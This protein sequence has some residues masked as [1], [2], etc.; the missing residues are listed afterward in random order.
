MKVRVNKQITSLALRG[1]ICATNYSQY[2]QVN[3]CTCYYLLYTPIG[4]PGNPESTLVVGVMSC[5][6]FGWG[7]E[8]ASDTLAPGATLNPM[9]HI[10]SEG[11]RLVFRL[12]HQVPDMTELYPG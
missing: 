4:K 9:P 5:H 1:E 2:K 12:L 6:A 11:S 3:L 10:C 8:E 7:G